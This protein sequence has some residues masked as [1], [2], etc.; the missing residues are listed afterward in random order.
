MTAVLWRL[1][2]STAASH[3]G[4]NSRVASGCKQCGARFSLWRLRT[5]PSAITQGQGQSSADVLSK[6]SRRAPAL[7]VCNARGAMLIRP[8]GRPWLNS[9]RAGRRRGH[10]GRGLPTTA[11]RTVQYSTYAGCTVAAVNWIGGCETRLLLR[12]PE[13]ADCRRS[14]Q[15]PAQ[16]ARHRHRRRH[17]RAAAIFCA[18][19]ACAP[20]V[21][22]LQS[23]PRPLTQTHRHTDTDADTRNSG[24][25]AA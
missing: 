17:K 18:S 12:H 14:D 15:R 11:A 9:P 4:S 1:V 24:P 8:R 7:A 23:V 6:S 13:T 5:F 21:C 22:S 25:P 16:R 3:R 2:C 20:A 19:C 10:R